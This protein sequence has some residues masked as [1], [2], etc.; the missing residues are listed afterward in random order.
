ML[1]LRVVV[2]AA[3]VASLGCQSQSINDVDSTAGRG[4]TS[5]VAAGNFAGAADSPIGGAGAAAQPDAVRPD[6][7]GDGSPGS[8]LLVLVY[9]PQTKVK[10]SA[11]ALAWNRAVEAELWVTLR[12][13]PAYS[14]AFDQPFRAHPI[15]IPDIRSGIGAKRRVRRVRRRV[16]SQAGVSD[17]SGGAW[18]SR[19]G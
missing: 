15:R 12:Q 18:M 16:G 17:L 6:A 7:L 13:L 2:A 3:L 11:T 1:M 4:G 10:L 9:R 8:A 14:A 19:A 5:G